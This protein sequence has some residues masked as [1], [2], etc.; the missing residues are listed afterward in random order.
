MKNPFFQLENTFGFL[1]KTHKP[2]TQKPKCLPALVSTRQYKSLTQS[3]QLLRQ[4]LHGQPKMT[5]SLYAPAAG[6]PKRQ[7]QS[8]Q[9]EDDYDTN[10]ND[11]IG[12]KF[13]RLL[14]VHRITLMLIRIIRHLFRAF[15]IENRLLVGKQENRIAE[16]VNIL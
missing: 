12:S 4:K 13:R 5:P 6:M 8:Q 7:M 10:G 11:G 14:I 9:Q 1:P 15:T 3:E 2:L 16:G